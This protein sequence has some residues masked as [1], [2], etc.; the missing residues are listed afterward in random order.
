[1]LQRMQVGKTGQPHHLLVQARVVLHRAGAKR[2]EPR[3][4]G[5][6]FLRKPRVV[7]HD[8]RFRESRQTDGALAL[9]AAEAALR[10]RRFRQIDARAAGRILLEDQRLLDLQ[11]AVAA[12]GA[13][14]GIALHHSTSFSTPTSAS[15]S[16]SV[17][18]SVAASSSRFA[19]AGSSG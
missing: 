9:E 16:A 1:R 5:I 12:E 17:L 8:L 6:V 3:V 7:A 14:D 18:V 19:S 2:I 13:G 11:A 4:D 10:L 15:M